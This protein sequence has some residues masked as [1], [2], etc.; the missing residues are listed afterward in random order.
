[1]S[2]AN[3]ICVLRE[4]RERLYS[5]YLREVNFRDKQIAKD[6]THKHY[7]NKFIKS[8]NRLIHSPKNK[9]LLRTLDQADFFNSCKDFVDSLEEIRLFEKRTGQITNNPNFLLK[10]IEEIDER[11]R[12]LKIEQNKGDKK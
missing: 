8:W 9:V 10:K 3:I 5:Q 1:M 6:I 11:I 4:K 12:L 7:K 2:D